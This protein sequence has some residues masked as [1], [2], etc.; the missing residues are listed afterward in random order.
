[1]KVPKFLLYTQSASPGYWSP[2]IIN[3]NGSPYMIYGN[4]IEEISSAIQAEDELDEFQPD[5]IRVVNTHDGQLFQLDLAGQWV[6]IHGSPK[7]TNPADRYW[8][9]EF[10]GYT[11]FNG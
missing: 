2:E 5:E 8:L 11:P 10:S 6:E 1:V 9:T 4:T 7:L 3:Y